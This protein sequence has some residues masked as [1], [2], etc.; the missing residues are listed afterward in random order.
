MA[1]RILIIDDDFDFTEAIS[2]LLESKG[3]KVLSANN[4]S[5]G[6][7][8]AKKEN[9]D[10]IL[11][12]VMMDTDTE[13]FDIARKLHQDSQTTNVPVII[14]TG[15]RREMNISFG[16]EPDDKLLPVRKVLEKP[17]KPEVLLEVIAENII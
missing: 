3:Y 11:L 15:I 14:V 8:L 12:D 9:P 13:G 7:D 10:L 2:R 16:F 5:D 6:L 17:L 4:G 1:K